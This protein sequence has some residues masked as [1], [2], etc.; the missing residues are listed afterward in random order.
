VLRDGC[1]QARAVAAA[2]LE[3]VRNAMG[4]RY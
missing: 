2:T 3:D 4:T 1:A